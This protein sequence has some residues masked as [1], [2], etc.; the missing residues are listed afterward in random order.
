[1]SK[2]LIAL[3]YDPSAQEV[4]EKGFAFAKSMGA[5]V[6]LLHVT[7]DYVYY[8]SLDYS[9]ILGY[10]SFSNLGALQTSTLE[11]LRIAAEN[12][13]RSMKEHLGDPGIETLVKDGEFGEVIL[14]TA[15]EN[16]IDVVV[17]GTHGRRGLD[18]ILMGSVAEKVLQKTKIP[19][20][21]IPTHKGE[22]EK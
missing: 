9:P 10:D 11:D 21:I 17:L 22:E 7:S 15:E 18:K 13:L 3:D 8:S 12:Y 16:N 19:L 2:V 4:A 5:Q 14:E 6:V 1:M 20:F